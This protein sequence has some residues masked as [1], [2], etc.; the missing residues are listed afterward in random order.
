[1]SATIVATTTAAVANPR[2]IGNINQ[3]A[4]ARVRAYLEQFVLSISGTPGDNSVLFTLQRTTTTGTVTSVTP[5]ATDTGGDTSITLVA[6][7]N[8]TAEPTYTS[9][10][11]L[12]DNALNGRATLV[13]VYAP[14]RERIVPLTN[15][16]GLGMKATHASY[17]GNANVTFEWHE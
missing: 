12:F 5:A 17:T 10:T 15:S 6:G 2:T 8:A 13:M 11:E 1:M 14:G 7:E 4:T 9:A 16:A 3:P